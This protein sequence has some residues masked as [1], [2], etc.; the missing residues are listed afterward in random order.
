MNNEMIA[1][2]ESL[3][4]E[5]NRPGIDKL[6]QFIRKSDFYTAPASTRFHSCHEGGLLEHSLNVYECLK[7]KRTNPL[8][9]PFLEELKDE[10]IA[11]VALLHDLCKTNFYTVEYKNKKV[12]KETG[13]KVDAQGHYDWESVPGYSID[14]KI[15]YGHGEKSVMM[16]EQFMKITPIERMCIRW[17][18]GW[19]EPKEVYNSVGQAFK[20]YPV[21][22]ALHEAD[23]EATYLLEKEE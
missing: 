22:I 23:L 10:G 7:K 6:I 5:T 19:T 21:I 14:D 11:I 15:P 1:K 4:F 3:L 13:K 17:H 16:I 9:Q 12:Y 2:F 20:L 18:M 8:W